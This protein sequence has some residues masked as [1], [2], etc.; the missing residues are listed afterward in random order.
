MAQ[1]WRDECDRHSR[2]TRRDGMANRRHG[3]VG[4]GRRWRRVGFGSSCLHGFVLGPRWKGRGSTPGAR[5]WRSSKVVAASS[6]CASNKLVFNGETSSRQ[7]TGAH[8]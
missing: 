4:S 7:F 8:K 1:S 3:N 2:Q 6:Q 5:A